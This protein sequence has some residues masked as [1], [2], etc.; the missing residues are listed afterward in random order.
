VAGSTLLTRALGRVQEEGWAAT[1]Q[2]ARNRLFGAD[3]RYVFVRHPKPPAQPLSL[4]TE[5]RGVVVRAATPADAADSHMRQHRPRDEQPV[6]DLFVA[7]RDGQ[8]V[9]AAWYTDVVTPSQPW[10]A[11]VAPHLELP[12]VFTANLFVVPGDKGASWALLKT[13]N[14]ALA[15]RGIRTIV[16]MISTHNSASI[17]M[18]RLLGARLC[19]RVTI[20]YWCGLPRTSVAAVARDNDAALQRPAP[21]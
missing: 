7:T 19:A 5:Q 10:Y 21:R 8:I 20:R 2:R 15:Q 4:P 16:G 12:A 18:A 3:E 11:A 13:A 9:G 17:L 14:E 6:T 1:L